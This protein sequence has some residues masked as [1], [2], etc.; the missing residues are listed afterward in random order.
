MIQA[1]ARGVQPGL[2][3]GERQSVG[4]GGELRENSFDQ[5]ARR[6]SSLDE[7]IDD[8]AVATAAEQDC[9]GFRQRASGAAHLLIVMHDRAGE[10][11]VN[12][13]RQVGFIEA[14]AERGRGDKRLEFVAKEARFKPLA[15]TGLSEF[16]IQPAPIRLGINAVFA[17]PGRH[18]ARVTNRERVNHPA[19]GKP[20]QCV[21]EPRQPGDFAGQGNILQLQARPRQPAALDRE[22]RAELRLQ[23]GDDPVVR[24]GRGGKHAKIGRQ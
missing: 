13:E 7:M 9:E 6:K 17:Q 18:R 14:H 23:V 12:H 10:L 20:G 24:R 4:R 21:R 15:Q 2:Q 1:G 11:I 22:R 8:V 3:F 19:A 5:R 16:F